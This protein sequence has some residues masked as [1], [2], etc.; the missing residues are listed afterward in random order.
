VKLEIGDYMQKTFKLTRIQLR[1]LISEALA[2]QPSW[3]DLVQNEIASAS[4]NLVDE[5]VAVYEPDVDHLVDTL[6][7][8][9]RIALKEAINSVCETI[10]SNI[11]Q[12]KYQ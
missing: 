12:G 2:D 4:E 11:D 1:A 8:D 3:A 9:V 10:C 6:R 5:I 7:V